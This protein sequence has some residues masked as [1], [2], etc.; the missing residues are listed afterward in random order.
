MIHIEACRY[1]QI[2][3]ERCQRR[4]DQTAELVSTH[5]ESLLF[6]TLSSL[7]QPR[8]DRVADPRRPNAG[9][10]KLMY[11]PASQLEAVS[12][13][14]QSEGYPEPSRLVETL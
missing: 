2:V 10:L 6:R 4:C 14:N 5:L 12:G 1:R 7:P 13:G 9:A 8:E 11:P 3:V